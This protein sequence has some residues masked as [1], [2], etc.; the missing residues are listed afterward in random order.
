MA[1][2]ETT[3][4]RPGRGAEL[5]LLVLA[6]A[7]G[8]GAYALVGLQLTGELPGRFYVYSIGTVVLAGAA[9]VLLRFK[10][11]YADPVILPIAVALNGIGL[12]MIFRL[13]LGSQVTGGTQDLAPRQLQWTALGILCAFALVWFLRD[14][15]TLRRYTYT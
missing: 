2:V 1:T 14:H 15:R 3:E 6:L 11:P 13:D 12:A 8:I 9:H 10:A 4:V 5:G 7:L